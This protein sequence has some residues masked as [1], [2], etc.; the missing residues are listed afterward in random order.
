M[1]VFLEDEEGNDRSHR[2]PSNDQHNCQN[3]VATK[4]LKFRFC[5]D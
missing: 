4:T 3:D 5:T 1:T 2:K